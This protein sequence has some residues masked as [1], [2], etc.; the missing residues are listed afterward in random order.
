MSIQLT[1]LDTSILPIDVLS[2]YDKHFYDLVAKIVGAGVAKLFEIQGIRSVYSFLNIV[3]VFAI[4][5]LSCPALEDIRSSI[6]LEA[7]D[8]TFIV[9]PGFRSGVEYLRQLLKQK[10]EENLTEITKKSRRRKQ[11]AQTND[12]SSKNL[13]QDI[14]QDAA[15]VSNLQCNVT[16]TSELSFTIDGTL[17]Y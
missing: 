4:L 2:F 16:S 15:T 13:S 8:H 7:A 3:D 1:S 9:Q 6:S 17:C 5:E 10:H 11:N 14:S 12:N